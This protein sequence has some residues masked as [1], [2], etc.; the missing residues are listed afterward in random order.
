VIELEFLGTGTSTGVPVIG[1][2]CAVCRSDDPRDT[3][4]R[5][6]VLIRVDDVMLLVDTSP[7]LRYQM[8]RSGTRR[9][10]GVLFTHT[11]ADHTAGLD[12][13]RRFNAMQQAWIPAWAPENAAADLRE[14][15]GYAFRE[16]FPVFGM[17]P[18]LDL[19]VIRDTAPFDVAGVTVQPL[20]IMHGRLPVLGYRI[21][22]LAYL[23]DVKTISEASRDLLR[24]LDVLVLT[25]L[26]R[27]QHPAHM[28]LEEALAAIDEL[29]PRRA[30][31]SHIGH[32]MG[33][34]ADVQA[35]L[36]KNVQLAY[37]GMRVGGPDRIAVVSDVHGNMTAYDAVLADIE[38]RGIRRVI[39]L[40]DVIG[41]GPRGSAAVARTR[42]RCEATVRGNWDEFINSKEL[43][44]NRVQKWWYDDLTA[45]DRSWLRSLPFSIDL[46][47]S[48]RVVRLFHASS[49]SVF[50]RVRAQ[51]TREEFDLMFRNTEATGSGEEPSVVVYG[52]IHATYA[53]EQGDKTLINAGS[54]GNALDEPTAS[55][56]IL[57]GVTDGVG[58]APF[59]Y[60]I[61]RVP[62][63][64]EAE[65]LIARERGMLELDEYAVELRSAVYRGMQ[66]S[67]V[68]RSGSG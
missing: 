50:H 35:G 17:A 39:N 14:R 54:V 16:E 37:D 63:D 41:K 42:E 3:R 59:R 61:I 23:T 51:H 1:C 12:E 43:E 67:N 5:A 2:D 15:F 47:M 58:A 13:I 7:D 11:H 44:P 48:G 18:D 62:Y 4:L 38:A 26:R 29:K 68:A 22:N 45:E 34:Y 65:I 60:E 9:I 21:G 25:A 46:Q 8:L 31:L 36:P 6:S 40:G 33:L 49:D 27:D 56:V 30:Y 24:D 52:D 53:E 32:D 19:H 20:P 28:T 66:S 10:D 57:E 64:I 55:Y